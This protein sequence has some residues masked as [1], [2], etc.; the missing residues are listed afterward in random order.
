M[1]ESG[2]NFMSVFCWGKQGSGEKHKSIGVLVMSSCGM[3]D[4]VLRVATNFGH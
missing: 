3:T 2:P 1:G 4:K